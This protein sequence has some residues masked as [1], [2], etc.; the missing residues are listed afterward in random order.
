MALEKHELIH[1][2]PESALGVICQKNRG[3]FIFEHY[4]WYN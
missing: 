4:L 2:M 1:E 3:R